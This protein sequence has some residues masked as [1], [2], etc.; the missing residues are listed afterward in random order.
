[1]HEQRGNQRRAQDAVASVPGDPV[2]FD[3]HAHLHDPSFDADR[4]VTLQR[5]SAAGVGRILTV[6]CDVSDSERA[7]AV[8]ARFGL[9]WSLGVHPHEAKDAPAD[10]AAVFDALAGRAARRPVAVGETG[11][12]YY[13]DHSPRDVQR[14]VMRAQV[15]YAS[16][17]VLPVIFHHRDAFEDFVAVLRDEWSAS[18]RGVVHCFTGDTAQARTLTDEFGLF[19]GIGGVL[20]FKNA[21]PLRDAV[22]AVGL[23]RVILET[24]CPY[25]APV[26][27]RG[28]RNEPA[29]IAATAAMLA[30]VFG[31]S[32]REV[33]E[34]TTATAQALFGQ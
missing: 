20:T 1:M 26:P 23:E 8:A 22:E 3:T 27:H 4:D 11:L 17:R 10:I 24:D 15:R 33:A 32:D 7:A 16:E 25:L 5:A 6:G 9:D 18:M 14:A 21:Q 19:L 2:I 13:Y 12:D 28:S 34:K 29:F 30:T 31:I